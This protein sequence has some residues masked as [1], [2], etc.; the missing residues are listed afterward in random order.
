MTGVPRLTSS[1]SSPV[2]VPPSSSASGSL[3]DGTPCRPQSQVRSHDNAARCVDDVGAVSTRHEPLARAHGVVLIRRYAV[4][5]QSP[6][7]P[8]PPYG[9]T[10]SEVLLR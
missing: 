8:V 9:T 6:D 4:C 10:R 3:S 5:S 7:G 2:S 1:A